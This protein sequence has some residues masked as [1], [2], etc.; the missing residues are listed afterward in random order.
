[1]E[2]NNEKRHSTAGTDSQVQGVGGRQ[3]QPPPPAGGGGY[4]KK[5]EIFNFRHPAEK[6]RDP[7]L[8]EL[9]KMGLQRVWLEVAEAIGVDDLLAMWR[10]ISSDPSSVGDHGRILVP[11]RS[12]S[13][14]LRYQRNR[15]I[16]A[17]TEMGLSSEEIRNRLSTQMGED[18]SH[19]NISRIQRRG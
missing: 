5:C 4:P 7:R 13:S 18:V 12:Y 19:R 17:L 6:N 3:E 1:M 10:I 15:Y 2:E 9:Q 16:E 11:I 14:Y 8:D